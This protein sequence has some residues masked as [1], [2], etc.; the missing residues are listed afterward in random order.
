MICGVCFRQF[1]TNE[2]A[3]FKCMCGSHNCRGTL[4]PKKQEEEI[5]EDVSRNKKNETKR[6][7][8]QREFS[9]I[10]RDILPLCAF[11]RRR[12]LPNGGEIR[13]WCRGGVAGCAVT[14]IS[15]A[16]DEE[17]KRERERE[18]EREKGMICLACA[19]KQHA[20]RALVLIQPLR[21]P[22][23]K[24]K[25]RHGV[26]VRQGSKL[27]GKA[28][29]EMLQKRERMAK[30]R[31]ARSQV[32]QL[33]TS[34]RLSLTGR[35]LPGDRTAEV[36]AGPPAKYFGFARV[37]TCFFVLYEISFLIELACLRTPVFSLNRCAAPAK[38]PT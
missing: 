27:K 22:P 32:G 10:F 25:T 7:G 17:D 37:R 6:E 16:H 2:K 36:K 30:N 9:R 28:R 38:L 24:Q 3:R 5:T 1:S 11:P 33:E 14:K 8:D 4:A 13:C 23:K 31:Q 19:R 12:L 18:R 20:H 15:D 34:K 29:K 26:P 21:P 35:V